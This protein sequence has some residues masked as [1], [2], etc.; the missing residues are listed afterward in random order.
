MEIRH[1]KAVDYETVDLPNT[2]QNG[3]GVI[4]KS[5]P[6][7]NNKNMWIAIAVALIAILIT[8]ILVVSNGR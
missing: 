6:L 5:S 8:L 7:K 1:K 4:G 2:E 3:G